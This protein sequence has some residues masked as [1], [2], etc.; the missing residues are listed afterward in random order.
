MFVGRAPRD[1]AGSSARWWMQAVVCSLAI[2]SLARAETIVLKNGT[3]VVGELLTLDDRG[4]E[5]RL[6]SGRRVWYETAE[7]RSIDAPMSDLFLQAEAEWNRREDEAA[8]HH[9]RDALAAEQRTWARRR[10]EWRMVAAY[11]R[12]GQWDAAGRLFLDLAQNRSDVAVMASTPLIWTGAEPISPSTLT[13]ARA[14]LAD[15]R[16]L[17]RLLAASWLLD[18]IQRDEARVV[19]DELQTIDPRVGPL[20][21]A[22]LWR[23]GRGS[24]PEEEI[25]RMRTTLAKLPE[26]LRAGPQFLYARALDESGDV[27]H[28]ALAYL[29]IPYVYEPGTDLA[30]DALLR[31]ALATQK[32]GH[33]DEAHRLFRDVA[34]SFPGS[35]WANQAQKLIEK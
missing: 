3:T 2:A 35:T 11:R 24:R 6:D 10:I 17:A 1:M 23:V 18:S 16:P 19:L 30:A 21:R 33:R 5:I 26:S 9:L 8:L 25:A 12:L 13:Q 22:Q 31:A 15:E 20:A 34:E 28:A 29:W 27:S 32:A 14:W 7:I 4:A